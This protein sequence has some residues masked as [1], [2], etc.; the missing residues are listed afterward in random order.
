MKAV[1]TLPP[2]LGNN[3]ERVFNDSIHEQATLLPV[4]ILSRSFGPNGAHISFKAFGEDN[5]TY[6]CKG[7]DFSNPVRMREAIYGQL[8]R[9]LGIATPPMA[10]LLDTD[11]NE[12]FFGSL[13]SEF[14]QHKFALRNFLATSRRDEITQLHPD[15]PGRYFAKLYVLDMFLYN[16][17]RA[18]SNLV[19]IDDGNMDKLCAIDFALCELAIRPIT[20]FPIEK[21]ETVVVGKMLQKVHGSF[22]D[23]AFEMIDR[24]SNVPITVIRSFFMELPID[25]NND[26]EREKLYGIWDGPKLGIRLDALRERIS[27]DIKN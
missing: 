25:W 18:A 3:S 5:N 2:L 14:T 10:V 8:A 20:E 16:I 27:H 24:I 13:H 9:H 1:P 15:W 4:R 21:S 22:R 26:G 11:S 17:D 23:S 6:Y 19:L 7:D 12:I